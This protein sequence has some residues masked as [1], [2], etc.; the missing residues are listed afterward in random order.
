MRQPAPCLVWDRSAD[1]SLSQGGSCACHIPSP[2]VTHSMP[3]SGYPAKSSKAPP[4]S[5]GLGPPV[6]PGFAPG[7]QVAQPWDPRLCTHQHRGAFS[8]P[9]AGTHPSQGHPM[10]DAANFPLPQITQLSHLS[11]LQ[12]AMKTRLFSHLTVSSKMKETELSQAA[13]ASVG[14]SDLLLGL[15]WV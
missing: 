3:R 4:T 1:T 14:I 7:S 10:A 11:P 6:A 2:P 15:G 8:Q 5:A 13:E 9:G 12:W